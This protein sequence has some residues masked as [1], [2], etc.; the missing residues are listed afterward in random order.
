MGPDNIQY[1]V[2][3]FFTP[4]L[5]QTLDGLLEKEK[6]DI[7]KASGTVSLF[8]IYTER[9][10]DVFCGS[11]FSFPFANADISAMPSAEFFFL[12]S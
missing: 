8:L 1:V 7:R 3:E 10:Q 12:G 5:Q 9:G 11:F 2:P 6:L 4:A